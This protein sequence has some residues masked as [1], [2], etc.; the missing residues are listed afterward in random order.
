[1]R[2]IHFVIFAFL[3]FQGTAQANVVATDSEVPSHA[4]TKEESAAIAAHNRKVAKHQ[5][6]LHSIDNSVR[7]P[8][9]EYGEAGYLIF[10][11]S[12][13]LLAGEAKRKMAQNLPSD[14]K[15]I[16][17]TGV[18]SE[19]YQKELFKD[20][21]Q[22]I[23]KDRLSVIYLSMGKRG[24]WARDGVPVPT[25]TIEDNGQKKF[26]VVDAKYYHK[27]EN[28]REFS[29]YFMADLININPYMN[30][31]GN[32]LGNEDGDCIIV[33]NER[34]A[35]I[36][37]SAYKSKYGCNKLLRLPHTKGI[38]HVDE[39]VKFMDKDT[40][41][42]DDPDYQ[43]TLKKAGYDV[44]KMPRPEREYETYVNALVVNGTAFVP[45]FNEATDIEAIQI[46]E[47]FGLRVVPL[48]S[49]LLSNDG[50][51]SIHCITMVYPKGPVNDVLNA[52][53]ASDF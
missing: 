45:V 16:V 25:W 15:L 34:A 7:L 41:I 40:V 35:Q 23:D 12:N 3:A 1:M 52:I 27:F 22:Y 53:T 39:S 19:Q 38:G 43:E 9:A 36:P 21:A 10:N 47:S 8:W 31:G 6:T 13:D 49:K 18:D 48:N 14:M 20:F 33:D 51:G 11:D 30:E 5:R 24:F 44:V 37:D 29:E 32:F 4:Y 17:Y 26:G 50:L 42:S 28:D 2:L 46:Y